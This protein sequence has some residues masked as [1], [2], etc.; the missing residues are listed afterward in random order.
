MQIV[1]KSPGN[2]VENSERLFKLSKHQ[3]ATVNN[4]LCLLK[5]QGSIVLDFGREL[6]GGL[7]IV[8]G[9]WPGNMGMGPGPWGNGMGGYW[10]N[11]GGWANGNGAFNAQY[12]QYFS[13]L[14][15]TLIFV[16][17]A[18]LDAV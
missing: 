3:S 17:A 15:H 7:E 2:Q 8:T 10:G 5:N 1:W 9:M 16:A 14:L 11:T 13:P 6:H 12:Q 4:D 18:G